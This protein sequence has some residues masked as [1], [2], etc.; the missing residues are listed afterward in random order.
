MPGTNF[1][2]AQ[3]GGE[4]KERFLVAA[5]LIKADA[6]GLSLIGS[7]GNG[8]GDAIHLIFIAPIDGSEPFRFKWT[9]S[10]RKCRTIWPN[11]GVA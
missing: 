6:L 9:S 2:L 4:D 1:T 8:G 7:Y 10:T 5:L 3:G 11:P